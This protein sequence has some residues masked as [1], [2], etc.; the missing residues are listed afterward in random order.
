M[1]AKESQDDFSDNIW[2]PFDTSKIL[3]SYNMD[4]KESFCEW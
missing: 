4:Y 3:G 2:D 1:E